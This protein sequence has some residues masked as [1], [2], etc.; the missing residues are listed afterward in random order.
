MLLQKFQNIMQMLSN[1]FV[2]ECK[3][4]LGS[5]LY[6]SRKEYWREFVE[7]TKHMSLETH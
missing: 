2:Q 7:F 1:L 6:D 4:V 3:I 5:E